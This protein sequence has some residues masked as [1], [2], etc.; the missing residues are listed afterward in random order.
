MLSISI[1]LKFGAAA[2]NLSMSGF[3]NYNNNNIE[4]F[5]SSMIIII[6]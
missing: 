5:G 3:F 4:K 1:L 2:N 6:I